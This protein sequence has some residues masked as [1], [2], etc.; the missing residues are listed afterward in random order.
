MEDSLANS[1]HPTSG[2]IGLPSRL[3]FSKEIFPSSSNSNGN[4]EELPLFLVEYGFGLRST[5]STINGK[6]PFLFRLPLAPV[7]SLPCSFHALLLV[8]LA[9]FLSPS[10][11]ASVNS[12]L[13]PISFSRLVVPFCLAMNSE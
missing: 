6:T 8:S 1:I 11:S 10:S 12:G 2:H 3:S 7:A 4:S 5:Q 13:F 9:S